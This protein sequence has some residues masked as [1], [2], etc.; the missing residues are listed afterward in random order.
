MGVPKRKCSRTRR[1]KR[2]THW[3]LIPPAV[4]KCS[5][6]GQL[7]PSHYVCPHCGYYGEKKVIEVKEKKKEAKRKQSR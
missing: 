2:A 7:R 5:H 1:D 4:S 6:C 3:K